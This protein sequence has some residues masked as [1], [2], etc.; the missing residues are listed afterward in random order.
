MRQLQASKPSINIRRYTTTPPPPSAQHGQKKSN[1]NTVILVA[2]ALSA[3]GAYFYLRA[4]TLDDLPTQASPGEEGQK[5][6]QATD[7]RA[8]QEQTKTTQG[9]IEEAT[10]A[11]ESHIR[12]SS[13]DAKAKF[14]SY[15]GSASG[16]LSKSR[17]SVEKMYDDAKSV[18][19]QKV[20]DIQSKTTKQGE[21]V[22][23]GW[24]DWLGWGKSQVKTSEDRLEGTRK[25]AANT[26]ANAAE[27]VR[28]GAE[29]RT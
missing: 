22:K 2:G 6:R 25:G 15:K 20:A 12:G 8:G 23:Q 28:Q 27:D 4:P 3:L 21:Q 9:K 10:Q 13:A 14:D 26:V 1:N 5:G 19:E 11:A 24:F 17:D 18:T 7:T 16:A 29:K